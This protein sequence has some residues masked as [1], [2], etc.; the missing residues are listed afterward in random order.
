[1]KEFKTTVLGEEWTIS[2]RSEDEDSQLKVS[3]GYTDITCKL[4]VVGLQKEECDLKRPMV[5]L[6]KVLR[7]ELVHAFM[8]ESGLAEN[9]TH[10]AMGQE[11]M[12]VDWIAIQLPKIHDVCSKAEAEMLILLAADDTIMKCPAISIFSAYNNPDMCSQE[13]DKK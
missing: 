10:A 2:L 6:R 7:H 5:Y 13:G 12:V 1:M 11:E 8:F 3:D 4:I 9:W